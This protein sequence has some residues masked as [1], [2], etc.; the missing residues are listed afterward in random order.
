M[1]RLT[2]LEIP[3]ESNWDCRLFGHTGNGLTWTP[4]E[5]QVPNRWIRFWMK[6]FLGCVWEKKLREDK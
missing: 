5:G 6:V 4:T 2:K 3:K 1:K